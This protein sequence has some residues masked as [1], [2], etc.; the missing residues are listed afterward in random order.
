M[1]REITRVD[2]AILAWILEKPEP[3][4]LFEIIQSRLTENNNRFGYSLAST[5]IER[6]YGKVPELKNLSI[7]NLGTLTG[8]IQEEKEEISINW[9]RGDLML[10]GRQKLPETIMVNL[11]GRK[12]GEIIKHKWLPADA[13]IVDITAA[14]FKSWIILHCQEFS[15]PLEQAKE[16]LK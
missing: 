2:K 3:C 16:S 8:E 14:Y 10:K 6:V 11:A 12:L 15:I 4:K 7:T 5:A 1:S 13:L 9:N